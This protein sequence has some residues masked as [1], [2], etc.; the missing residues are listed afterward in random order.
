MLFMPSTTGVYNQE[1]DRFMSAC[2]DAKIR[3]SDTTNG[4]WRRIKSINALDV[5]WSI[6]DVDFS[7]DGNYII[8][9]S[10]SQNIH[11]CNICG[12]EDVHQ[13][14]FLAPD[15]PYRTAVFSLRFTPDDSEIIAGANNGTIFIFDRERNERTLM[16]DAHED[17]LSSVC[18]ASESGEIIYSGG[19]DGPIKIWDRR[20]LRET[21]PQPIGQLAGHFDSITHIDSRQDGRYLLTNSKDQS[22]KL[23]DIRKLATTAGI[24]ATRRSVSRQDWD[25]RWHSYVGKVVKKKLPGDC[26]VMTYY[27]HSVARTLIRARFSPRHTT[28]QR[29]IYCGDGMGRVIIYNLLTGQVERTL[30]GGHSREVVRDVSWHPYENNI[31][32]SGWDGKLL[33]WG[34]IRPE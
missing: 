3:I 24:E 18:L 17:D 29:F 31:V 11:L 15:R 28:G 12:D 8:Y 22:I 25:Y 6:L 27:G 19:E 1:G 21:N 2:Q 5:G 10:W 23:W 34:N 20:L 26:S 14:L 4:Q 13:A 32:S 9:S 7:H 30:D 16:I 33:R